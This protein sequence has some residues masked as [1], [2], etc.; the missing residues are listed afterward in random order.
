[1]KLNDSS[2][3][4]LFDNVPISRAEQI[5]F[6]VPH[7]MKYAVRNIVSIDGKYYYVKACTPKIL[8]NELIGSY[9]SSLIGLDAVEYKIGRDTYNTGYLY[10]LSEVFYQD[11][12][13]YHTV[14]RYYGM[15][16]DD[17]SVYSKGIDR[18]YICD[19]SILDYI[20]S[21]KL[22]DAVIKMSTVDIKMGQ[23]DRYDYN[24]I[25]RELNG[26]IE[27]EKVYDFGA[28][29]QDDA[30]Y[31]LYNCYYNPFLL[32]KRNTISLW[33]L[34][35]KYPQISGS[36]AILCSTPLYDVIKDI[37][38]QFNIKIEDEDIKDSLE[39]DKKFS[40]ILRKVR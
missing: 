35:H 9:F 21:K 22:S 8:L 23:V 11:E 39:L 29:Y 6:N 30:G 32:V 18:H 40:K 33:G 1:M 36:A 13:S 31:S 37:E 4:I 17:T 28:S 25:L 12:C 7:T 3:V 19:T 24:V 10:A 15:R 34:A 2:N 27:L 26:I 14:D 5:S 16:P 38:S 20:G